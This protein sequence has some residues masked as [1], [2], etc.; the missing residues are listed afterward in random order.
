MAIARKRA[1]EHITT[2]ASNQFQSLI[3]LLVS[4]FKK[5]PVLGAFEVEDA[6]KKKRLRPTSL[7]RHTKSK[8][9]KKLRMLSI[10]MNAGFSS[11]ENPLNTVKT[12]RKS[13]IAM[14]TT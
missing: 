9:I 2:R 10:R 8:I 14:M 13:V 12:T 1:K 3:L 7:R 11:I 5:I 4:P 6:P